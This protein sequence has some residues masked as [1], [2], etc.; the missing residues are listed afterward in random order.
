MPKSNAKN[1]DLAQ[2]R[3][4]VAN[5]E[6]ELNRAIGAR[7]NAMEELKTKFGCKTIPQAKAKLRELEKESEEKEQAFVTAYNSYIEKH[8]EE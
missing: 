3:T 6:G 5:K 8:G 2:L 4:F 7:D 1:T